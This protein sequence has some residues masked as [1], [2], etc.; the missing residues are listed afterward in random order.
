MKVIKIIN[1]NFV[2]AQD[3]DK[4]VVIA[5][6]GI[7]F[8]TEVNQNVNVD[9][10]S[11]FFT[12]DY[13]KDR[14]SFDVF[15]NIPVEYF[16]ISQELV[17][18]YRIETGYKISDILV[19]NLADH[20]YYVINRIKK[21]QFFEHKLDYEI[22]VVY[23]FEYDLALNS[24]KVLSD[25]FKVQIPKEEAAFIVSHI[26]NVTTDIDIK[27]VND[28]TQIS[29]DILELVKSN[30]SIEEKSLEYHRFKLHVRALSNRII[31][32]THLNKSTTEDILFNSIKDSDKSITNL[33][34][35]I[36]TMLHNKFDSKLNES[37]KLYLILHISRL[38]KK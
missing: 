22:S 10:D 16:E 5:R 6:K 3:G 32:D 15:D 24:L 19:F 4:E 33:V 28:Q 20:L 23:P 12:L 35:E 11:K 14:V 27:Q 1:N 30:I 8:N 34:S 29:S 26:I 38:M 31:K 7:G 9:D 25:L 13:N 37:E 17:N 18:M 36:D 21:N 2:L